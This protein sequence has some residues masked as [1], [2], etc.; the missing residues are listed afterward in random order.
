MPSVKTIFS[1]SFLFLA[2]TIIAEDQTSSNELPDEIKNL[3]K[4][5]ILQPL[6]YLGQ[7]YPEQAS[8]SSTKTSVWVKFKLRKNGTVDT[9][10]VVYCEEPNNGFEEFALK[11][12]LG[13]TFAVKFKRRRVDRSWLYTNVDFFSKRGK[14]S[15]EFIPVEVM[16]E[17]I[18][19]SRPDY[20]SIARQKKINA[21]VWVKVLIDEFGRPIDAVIQ[22]TTDPDWKYGF[23]KAALK[24][25][26][27]CVFKPGIQNGKPVK[28]WVTFPYE[29]KLR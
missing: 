28:V 21:K 25:V 2:A 27:K 16:P 10:V 26:M 15:T 24:A 11:S 9:A 1:I 19:K 12:V 5:W 7:Y 6:N 17:L 20:P 14:D 3:D 29:F 18:R 13:T 22:K 8:T 23:N 4:K